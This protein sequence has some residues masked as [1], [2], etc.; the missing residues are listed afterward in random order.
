[1]AYSNSYDVFDI[2]GPVMIG[3]S[4]SHTAGAVRIGLMAGQLCD[5][6]PREISLFFHGSLASTYANH[7]TDVGVTA[8]I[9]GIG[10]DDERIRD[11]VELAAEREIRTSF[12]TISLQNA[13]PSTIIIEM[14]DQAGRKQVMRAATVGGGN[15]FIEEVNGYPVSLDGKQNYIVGLCTDAKGAKEQLEDMCGRLGLFAQFSAVKNQFAFKIL[16]GLNPDEEIESLK[17]QD[18]VKEAFLLRAVMPLGKEND[19]FY[20]SC[21]ELAELAESSSCPISEI[22]MRFEQEKSNRDRNEV[23][24]QMRKAYHVMQKSVQDGLEKECK[25]LG[26]IFQGNAAKMDRFVRS[27]GSI[28]GTTLSKVVR[29]ALAVMEVNGSMGKVVACPTAGSAGTVPAVVV[30]L[31]QENNLPEDKVVQA[32]FTGAG[33][34]IIIAEHA[35]ISGAVG[36]CQAEC[37]AASAM[38]A[39]ITTEIYGG[40][41]REI[42]SAVSLALGNVLGMVCDPVAGMVEIPCIQRNTVS[43]ANAILAAE[44]ALAGVD[45]VIPADE[46]IAALNEV[47]Q[48]MDVKLKDS[49]GAGISNTPTARAIEK[50]FLCK[51]CKQNKV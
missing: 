2:I 40:G 5:Y 1:M 12:Q 46:M 30:T 39:A 11:A 18:C 33:I 25:L 34:G 44:M 49:L 19:P 3:P 15:I 27:G 32:M 37:G 21:R 7:K 41:P 13:H 10:V 8:G 42:L 23:F 43:A 16:C 50:Q 9:L 22:V 31:A 4:S 20:G 17:K 26:G 14:I 28:A 45:S 36:G 38:A 35:T 47:A 29:N 24:E 6:A 48:L 51:S